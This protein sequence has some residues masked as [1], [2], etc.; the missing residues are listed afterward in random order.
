MSRFLFGFVFLYATAACGQSL[1]VDPS[2]IRFVGAACKGLTPEQASFAGDRLLIDLK[3][4]EQVDRHSPR[5]SC[6]IKIPYTEAKGK[7]TIALD[8]SYEMGL[9]DRLALSWR[10]D[11]GGSLGPAKILSLSESNSGRVSWQD[12]LAFEGERASGLL[13]ISLYVDLKTP[14]ANS[15]QGLEREPQISLKELSLSS[16]KNG[17]NAL[18]SP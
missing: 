1:T 10:F 3:A 9:Q 6:L 17:T 15:V 5:A 12:S 14:L 8:G 4:M 7:S 11:E 16:V 13:R 18:N 2:A